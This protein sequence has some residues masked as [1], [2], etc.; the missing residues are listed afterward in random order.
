MNPIPA[1]G[2]TLEAS[3]ASVV[4]NLCFALETS[5]LQNHVLYI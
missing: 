5:P 1:A 2:F 4:P 3:M